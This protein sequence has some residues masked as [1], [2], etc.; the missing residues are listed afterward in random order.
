MR[1]LSMKLLGVAIISATLSS[2][3]SP[4]FALGGCGPNCRSQRMGP[5]RLGRPERGLVPENDR[6]SGHAHAQW[7]IALLALLRRWRRVTRSTSPASPGFYFR[8]VV[9]RAPRPASRLVKLLRMIFSPSWRTKSSLVKTEYR[10]R[11]ARRRRRSRARGGGRR[12]RPC[13]SSGVLRAPRRG[14][15]GG[16]R[17]RRGN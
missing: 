4:A 12:L 9:D 2:A 8:G 6:P 7:D 1:K 15:S 5:M 10:R 3:I 13:R 14:S 11:S 16:P 17:R